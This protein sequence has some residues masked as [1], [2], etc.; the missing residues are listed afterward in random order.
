MKKN[1]LIYAK[2][3]KIKFFYHTFKTINYLLSV[4]QIKK[5]YSVLLV[6]RFQKI[7]MLYN[8]IVFLTL[9]VF[10][11]ILTVYIFE[12]NVL[13]TFENN[14][15]TGPSADRSGNKSFIAS[16]TIG[17]ILYF[18]LTSQIIK[19]FWTFICFLIIKIF[20]QKFNN[21]F[22][23]SILNETR[24]IKNKKVW[25]LKIFNNKFFEY[26]SPIY[27]LFLITFSFALLTSPT[28]QFYMPQRQSNLYYF[29]DVNQKLYFGTPFFYISIVSLTLSYIIFLII[30]LFQ[31]KNFIN[32]FFT[33]SED[34]IIKNYKNNDYKIL[35]KSFINNENSST[36]VDEV[37]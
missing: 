13:T 19:F 7:L 18:Q 11:I 22:K 36:I 17:N 30:L 21:Y 31:A 1:N 15:W 12:V 8:F 35:Q 24:L 16:I 28:L 37:K 2:L 26:I 3:N 10:A 32:L 25:Y 4:M 27:I 20:F 6:K 14:V 29:Y 5:D 9:F 34:N 33:K 23:K